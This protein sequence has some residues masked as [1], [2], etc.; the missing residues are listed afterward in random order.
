MN[1]SLTVNIIILLLACYYVVI[2]MTSTVVAAFLRS[3]R[4]GI[5]LVAT[6][7]REPVFGQLAAG[8]REVPDGHPRLRSNRGSVSAVSPESGS[9]QQD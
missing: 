3:Y 2:L 6:V 4:R 8:V 1:M 9:G 7:A 5:H